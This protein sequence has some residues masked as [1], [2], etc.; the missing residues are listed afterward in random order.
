MTE[1]KETNTQTAKTKENK[2]K[3]VRIRLPR[4]E[5]DSGDVF[6]SVNEKTFLIKRGVEVDVPAYV[7]EVIRHAEEAEEEAYRFKSGNAHA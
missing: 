5:K 1:N 4:S 3:T 7:A 2:E 6:V